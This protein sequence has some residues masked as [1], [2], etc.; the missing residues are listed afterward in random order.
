MYVLTEI[1]KSLK[2]FI[3]VWVPSAKHKNIKMNYQ[4]TG[5][6]F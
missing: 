4:V 2:I 1:H 6:P 5:L 3:Q